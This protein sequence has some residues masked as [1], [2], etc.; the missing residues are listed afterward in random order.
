MTD[1]ELPELTPEE[2][3][4]VSR[5]LAEA[6]GPL[7]MPDEVAARLEATLA[8][9]VEERAGEPEEPA[10]ATVVTLEE[11]R[12]ARRWPRLVLAAAAVVVAGYAAGTVVTGTGSG[13]DSASVSDAA[14][15]GEAEEPMAGADPE[16][17]SEAAP[18]ESGPGTAA[19]RDA[20]VFRARDVVRLRSETLEDDL[21]R[22]LG[23]DP[24]ALH[25]A[26]RSELRSQTVRKRA[27]CH[28]PALE[29]GQQW[30]LARYDGRR[31]VLVAGP[32]DGELLPVEVVGC[33]GVVLASVE[34]DAELD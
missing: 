16:A 4:E 34:V 18:E 28:P 3:T 24:T 6:G 9:L 19:E 22:A 12:A 15:A 10:A 32:D 29:P 21:G 23:G 27:T 13:S 17:A 11:R 26:G 1:D 2:E 14:G 8:G 31:A 30:A 7:P 33:D 25:D 20:Q 5:L